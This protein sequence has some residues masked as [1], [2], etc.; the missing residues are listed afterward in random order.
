MFFNHVDHLAN[1]RGIELEDFVPDDI[2]EEAGRTF[3]W[4]AIVKLTDQ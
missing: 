1:S 2:W 4:Q 3:D